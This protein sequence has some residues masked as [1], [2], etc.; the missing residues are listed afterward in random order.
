MRSLLRLLI[1]LNGT[2]VVSIQPRLFSDVVYFYQCTPRVINGGI[3]FKIVGLL[4]IVLIVQLMFEVGVCG[5]NCILSINCWHV[6]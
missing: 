6:V 4:C 3:R 2:D 1:E 5:L